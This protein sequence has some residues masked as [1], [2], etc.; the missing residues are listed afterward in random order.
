MVNERTNYIL[1]LSELKALH[2]KN[3]DEAKYD[4]DYQKEIDYTNQNNAHCKC[5][6]DWFDIMCIIFC[7]FSFVYLYI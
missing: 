2:K 6:F 3:D 4:S 7:I 1:S 5:F